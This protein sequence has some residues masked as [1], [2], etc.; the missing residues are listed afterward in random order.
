MNTNCIES[1][2]NLR[3]KVKSQSKN[4]DIVSFRLGDIDFSGG[5][6]SVNNNSISKKSLAKICKSM[7]VYD[8]FLDY[9]KSMTTDEWINLQQKLIELNSNVTFW[10]KRIH[11][12]NTNEISQVY[13]REELNE[14]QTNIVHI[15]YD[16]YFDMIVDAL[17]I[18]NYE[19]SPK[20]INF[21]YKNEQVFLQFLDKH[22]N[23]DIFGNSNDIWKRGLDITFD[24]LKFQGSPFFERLICTNGMTAQSYGFQANIQQKQWNLPQIQKEIN[25][26]IVGKP[27]EQDSMIIEQANLLSNNTLSVK[28]FYDFKDFFKTKNNEDGKYNH[29]IGTVFNESDIINAYKLDPKEKSKKWQ[30]TASSFRNSYDFFND[31]TYMASHSDNV[32]LEPEDARALS[33]KSSN[34]FFKKEFD[35]QDVAPSVNN[36]QLL[37]AYFN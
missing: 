28:E 22:N 33:I 27:N 21:D 23:V 15:N 31:M 14:Q 6:L 9:Q 7:R 4:S 8:N 36:R 13:S 3:E 29:I 32:R 10:G 17:E 24:L 5:K 16:Q 20:N 11:N 12:F 19:F 26:L 18:T 37:Q 35:L 2:E 1:V 25:R 34:L 30:S